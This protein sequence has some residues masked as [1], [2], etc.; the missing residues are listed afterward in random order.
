MWK[1]SAVHFRVETKKHIWERKQNFVPAQFKEMMCCPLTGGDF[2]IKIY[3]G[4]LLQQAMPRESIGNKVFAALVGHI[5]GFCYDLRCG[6]CCN[7]P[8]REGRNKLKAFLQ[9][10]KFRY[11]LCIFKNEKSRV[12]KRWSCSSLISAIMHFGCSCI[13]SF[14]KLGW[15]MTS[16]K[17]IT[18]L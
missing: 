14:Y 12:M 4:K 17:E 13:K 1:C 10:L 11:I 8:K 9:C 15:I 6:L 3:W 16:S 5:C 18:F 7:I 2:H